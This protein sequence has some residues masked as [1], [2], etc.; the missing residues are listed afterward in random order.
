MVKFAKDELG[1]TWEFKDDSC[2]FETTTLH[3]S[4]MSGLAVSRDQL[5][6]IHGGKIL[7]FIF[8]T[9]F[10][11]ASAETQIRNPESYPTITTSVNYENLAKNE[12]ENLT[13]KD[14]LIESIKL[15]RNIDK[16]ITFFKIVTVVYIVLS[17]IGALMFI[18]D[19]TPY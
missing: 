3:Y 19:I 6:F 11:A 13:E 10:D 1:N 5:T 16:N 2:S 18:S 8:D 14:L 9:P 7:T 4:D 17:V 15:Q 12:F